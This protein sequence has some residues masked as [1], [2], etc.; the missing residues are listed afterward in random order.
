[1]PGRLSE[2]HQ[3][4]RVVIQGAAIIQKPTT[5]TATKFTEYDHTVLLWGC[6][7]SNNM[8]IGS[9]LTQQ[10]KQGKE[11]EVH[12]KRWPIKVS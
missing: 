2:R 5:S 12:I 1:M 8:Q 7:A 9:S 6:K 10:G 11:G 3:A 4:M